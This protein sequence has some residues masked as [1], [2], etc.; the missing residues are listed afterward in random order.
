M[1]TLAVLAMLS[2]IWPGILLGV[3]LVGWGLL[4]S[5]ASTLV[6]FALFALFATWWA[7]PKWR[8]R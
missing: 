1:K 7:L 8:G 2:R 4:G 3:A 6:P 5:P